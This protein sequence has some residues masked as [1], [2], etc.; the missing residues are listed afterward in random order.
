LVGTTS[1]KTFTDIPVTAQKYINAKYRGYSKT[2]VLF[3][4]DNELNDTNMILY[5][6]QFDDAD[7][8]FVELRKNNKEI[9]LQVSMNGEVSFFKQLR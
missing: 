2:N 4:D 9:I 8:Y 6:D 3:F 1:P 5:G 7:N